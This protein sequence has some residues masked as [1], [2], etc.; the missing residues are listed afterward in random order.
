MPMTLPDDPKKPDEVNGSSA[1]ASGDQSPDGAPAATRSLVQ[2]TR[3][4]TP[5]DRR[6]SAH[7]ADAALRQRIM[8]LIGALGDPGHPLHARAVEDLVVLGEP[9]VP[10][11]IEALR[12]HEPW[13][14]AYR[15]TEALGQIGD[16]RAAGSLVEALRHPNSNVRW[17]AVRALATVGDARALLELRRVARTDRSKTSW[18]E[19]VGDTA[20][21]VLDQ[22]QSRTLL[23]RVAELVKTA[24]ACVLM[25]VSLIFAW[26][27]LTELRDELRQTGRVEPAPVLIAPPVNT[28]APQAVV[29]LPTLAPSPAASPSPPTTPTASEAPSTLTGVV[30][31]S[32]NV[33]A[34]PARLPDNVIGNVTAGDTLIFL[35][36]TPDGAWYRV[37]LGSPT[38]T[39]SQIRSVDGS[40]WVSA[41]LVTAPER[42]PVETPPPLPTP[43]P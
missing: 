17:G 18:G 14:L 42:V 43:T 30:I 1:E 37:Q 41:S 25:L 29:T 21:A 31:T 11:L 20:R 32:G 12:T 2:A 36:V 4:L 39:S 13:L 33:R 7:I 28:T 3:T 5:S 15:A 23:A 10:A 40:G 27:V 9:A 22:M 35:G 8:M 6:V 16:G 24:I 26:S 34:T 38:A 19:S